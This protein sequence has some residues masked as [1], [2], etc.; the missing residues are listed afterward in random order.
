MSKRHATRLRLESMEDRLVPSAL[1]LHAPA[2]Q[3]IA[4]RA[5]RLEAQAG[6]RASAHVTTS[7][8]AR[9]HHNHAKHAH[10]G[11]H[12]ISRTSPKTSQ[13][14]NTLSQFFKSIFGNL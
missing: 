10:A 11:H 6:H 12:A 1:G 8:A 7:H 9:Q 14:S 3:V 4:A 2:A 5:E 13:S